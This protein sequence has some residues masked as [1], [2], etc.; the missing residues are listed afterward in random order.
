MRGVFFSMSGVVSGGGGGAGR[1][2][3]EEGVLGDSIVFSLAI[4]YFRH[5]L[6]KS[7]F[8]R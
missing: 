7:G 3:E 5:A 4:D 1:V 2:N 6:G 8:G